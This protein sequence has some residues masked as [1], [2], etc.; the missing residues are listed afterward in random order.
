MLRF[1]LVQVASWSES[2]LVGKTLGGDQL[3]VFYGEYISL[4]P[5]HFLNNISDDYIH[6][7]RLKITRRG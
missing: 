2:V 5:I 6:R 1:D 3:V 4:Y 7:Y